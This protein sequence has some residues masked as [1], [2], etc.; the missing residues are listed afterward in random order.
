MNDFKKRTKILSQNNDPP[1]ITLMLQLDL[2]GL[3]LEHD[4]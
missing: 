1:T 4:L 3:S 2:H